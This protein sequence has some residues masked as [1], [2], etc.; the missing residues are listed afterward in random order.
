MQCWTWADAALYFLCSLYVFFKRFTFK[1]LFILSLKM[2]IFWFIELP[3]KTILEFKV[4]NFQRRHASRSYS[5]FFEF[6]ALS[7]ARWVMKTYKPQ[8]A[9]EI[10]FGELH[11]RI[12]HDVRR[13]KYG[14]G[15]VGSFR[16]S[17]VTHS[18]NAFKGY[19]VTSD[20]CKNVTPD[21]TIFFVPG[22]LAG[23]ASSYTYLEYVSMLLMDLQLQGF[24]HPTAFVLDVKYHGPDAYLNVLKQIKG[25]YEYFLN[26]YPLAS[27]MA[28]GSGIGGTMLC[29][30]LLDMARPMLPEVDLTQAVIEDESGSD[31]EISNADGFAEVPEAKDSNL[32][33]V[34]SPIVYPQELKPEISPPRDILLSENI[35]QKAGNT[36]EQD[37]FDD[38][39]DV[40]LTVDMVPKQD[41]QSILTDNQVSQ[42][43]CEDNLIPAVQLNDT[44]LQQPT[45]ELNVG[46][47]NLGSVPGDISSVC[48]ESIAISPRNTQSH[49]RL[50]NVIR[51]STP[52]K[53]S[54]HRHI[55]RSIEN[56]K[57]HKSFNC[58][59][60]MGKFSSENQSV[61]QNSSLLESRISH[62][63]ALPPNGIKD[64]QENG[65]C[66]NSEIK[67]LNNTDGLKK[68]RK[69]DAM[70]L[71]SP[72]SR[73]KMNCKN[74]YPDL[75]TKE[76][77]DKFA[78]RLIRPGQENEAWASPS[79]ITDGTWWDEALPENGCVIMYGT[80]E[81]LSDEIQGLLEA[82]KSCDRPRTI[83]HECGNQLHAWPITNAFISRNA[84]VQFMGINHTSA[85]IAKMLVMKCLCAHKNS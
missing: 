21:L 64:N 40:S 7:Y 53:E 70:L 80:G 17:K 6:C 58:H 20:S 62:S 35:P 28:M 29:T 78:E 42:N 49:T 61:L 72:F 56:L 60:S 52:S 41:C 30:F 74:K 83:G 46:V 10:F 84:S 31:V 3:V 73:V 8:Y 82:M 85:E 68:L 67:G 51:E 1:D 69:P 39:V 63:K 44:D 55:R 54:R 5:T 34:K 37:S 48:D 11:A 65:A 59:I 19:W 23:Y 47:E 13:F 66:A 79:T 71:I 77:V 16:R 15:N 24:V 26:T 2:P 50:T 38:D 27:V 33:F 36:Q 22:N 45:F 75:I 43:I 32:D 57:K 81:T 14:T 4:Y 25:A 9:E 12:L 18:D 76:V